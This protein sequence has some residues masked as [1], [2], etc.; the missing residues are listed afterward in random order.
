MNWVGIVTVLIF[1]I[2]WLGGVASW[3]VAAYHM[4][5]F[6]RRFW[7]AK[8]KLRDL[9]AKAFKFKLIDF[10]TAWDDVPASS[11]IYRRKALKA[12]AV[13]LGFWLIG[14]ASGAVGVWLGGWQ[15][16]VPH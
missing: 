3:F 4:F 1:V 14:F 9:I 2:A 8:P 7:Q 5:M 12:G 16:P 11:I 13:F 15:A 6:H 10:R